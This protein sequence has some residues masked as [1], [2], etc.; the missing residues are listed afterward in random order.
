VED[1]DRQDLGP[2]WACHQHAFTCCGGVPDELL[3][4]R[5]KPV[6]QHSGGLRREVHPAA[7]AVA[8]Q[9]GLTI[10]LCGPRPPATTGKVEKQV[11]TSREWFCRGRGGT[12][13]AN[14]HEQWQA[15]HRA[16]WR[17][18]VHRTTGTALDA[19][20]R[21]KQAA[22]RPLSPPPADV[23][24][25]T[26]RQVAKDGRCSFEGA[27]YSAPAEVAGQ[28]LA[29]RVFPDPLTL[30]TLEPIPRALGEHCRVRPRGSLVEDPTPA[31]PRRRPYARRPPWPPAA[32]PST[33]ATPRGASLAHLEVP[34]ARRPRT[35]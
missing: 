10:D 15:W 4:A 26:R 11:A 18:H 1:T 30:S 24:E 31:V 9:E 5:T 34:V 2:F 13:R 19:R 21:E 22:R 25:R 20:L 12:D 17:P 35:L 33:P 23:C 28:R 6:V 7:L 3:S 27:L 29:W 14:R 8:G 16:V 32:L